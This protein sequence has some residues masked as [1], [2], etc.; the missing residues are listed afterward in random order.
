MKI[1]LLA[2]LMFSGLCSAQTICNNGFAGIFPCN[3]IDLMKNMPFSQIGGNDF[4]TEGNDSWGWTDPQTGREYAIMGCT[5]HTA[6]VDITNPTAPIYKGR[7]PSRNNVSSPWRDIKVYNNYAFIVSEAQGHGIQIF[8]L[9]K[10]RTAGTSQTFTAD[11]LYSGFG[12][13]HNIAINEATGFAYCVGTSTFGGGPHV[14]LS[15]IHI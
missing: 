1:K 10:L 4:S 8:D 2:I 6:F 13:C 12:N 15:L 11:A 5:T 7:L 3:K 9:T 14:V